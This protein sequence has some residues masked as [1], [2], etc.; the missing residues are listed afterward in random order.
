MYFHAA[1]YDEFADWVTIMH[2]VEDEAALEEERKREEEEEEEEEKRKAARK[3]KKAAK[4]TQAADAVAA[5]PTPEEAALSPPSSFTNGVDSTDGS[6]AASISHGLKE[7]SAVLKI[8]ARFRCY[9]SVFYFSKALSCGLSDC[10]GFLV[11][12]VG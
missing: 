2:P 7:N 3:K 11:M 9:R 10:K 12:F 4:K 8:Q 5:I 6:L 1:N